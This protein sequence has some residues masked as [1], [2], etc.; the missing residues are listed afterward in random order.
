MAIFYHGSSA[1]F[2]KF[3]LSHVLEGDGKVKF[4]Y[5]VY[6]TSS[7][8]SASHYSGANKSV[9]TQ[10]VYTVEVPD[11][12]DDKHIDFKKPV[13]PDIVKRAE[14]KLG[15]TIPEKFTLDSKDFRKYLAKKFEKHIDIDLVKGQSLSKSL[16]LAGEKEAS[17]FLNSIGVEFITWPYSWKNPDLGL[18]VA[19]LDDQKIKITRIHQVELDAKQQLIPNSEKEITL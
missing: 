18:N 16:T 11:L 8:K 15:H 5:G 7:F 10:Y 17:E 2:P 14:V 13:H 19:V 6:L 12:T 9:T 4:G 3:D 1:L